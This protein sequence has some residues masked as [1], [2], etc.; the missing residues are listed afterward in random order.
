VS[1]FA[2][3][4]LL[5]ALGVV[6][7]AAGV[8]GQQADPPPEA[9]V[10]PRFDTSVGVTRIKAAVLSESGEP[11]GGLGPGDFRVWENEV[12]QDVSLVLDPVRFGLD[13]A[14]V[15][16]FSTSVARDWSEEAA[17]AAAHDFLDRLGGDDCVFLLPFNSSVGPGT[18][19]TPGDVF[20]RAAVDRQEFV[21]NTRLYDAVLVAHDALDQRRPDSASAA[22]EELDATLY[23]TWMEP[24]EDASCGEPLSP[25]EALERRAALV[26]LTDGEDS[27]SRASYADALMA[28]WRSEVP[29]FALGVGMAAQPLRY[30]GTAA[31]ASMRLR[32]AS[33]QMDRQRFEAVR[34]LQ[35][36]LREIARVSGGQLVLQEDLAKG[37]G[38]TLGLL[39][40]Y[41]VLAY[42]SPD[43]SGEGWQELKVELV[44]RRGDVIVQPGVYRASTTHIGAVNVLREASVKFQLGQFEEALADFDHVSRFNPDIGAPFFGRGLVLEK[45]GRDEEARD[46]YLRSLHQ[47]PGAPSTHARLA[48][49]NVRLGD[50]AAAWDHA[51][52]AHVAGYDQRDRFAQLAALAEPPADM[53]ER[54]ESPVVYITRPPA[55]ELEAQLALKDVSHALLAGLDAR[56]MLAAT[57]VASAADFTLTVWVRKFDGRKLSSRL[58]VFDLAERRRH[59]IGLVI[60]DVADSRS[61]WVAV[62]AA[63]VDADEW[64]Q[65]Q[66]SR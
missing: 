53:R 63:L 21:S 57:N 45:L 16:D 29:V 49:T 14:L 1:R 8:L 31:S 55:P 39:R 35:D 40:G 26:V 19:G 59:E 12:E 60:E 62:G 65:K 66:H 36:Q 38:Q 37:Y 64:I 15:L 50:Y 46:S 22:A 27:G 10:R 48:A 17:R 51:I 23:G 43:G 30:R 32:G 13:V 47:H 6:V 61:V 9:Q 34:A 25:E 52:R 18:W 28:S 20:L 5:S 58:V 24:V 42:P 11:I 54:L 56:N 41:Y 2:A 7:P 33:R 44:G 4:A 3:S